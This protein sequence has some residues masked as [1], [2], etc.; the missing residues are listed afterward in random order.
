MKGMEF[1]GQN[2]SMSSQLANYEDKFKWNH[3]RYR[4]DLFESKIL[5]SGTLTFFT[6]LL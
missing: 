6:L 4:Q 5:G 1:G 2:F 3:D